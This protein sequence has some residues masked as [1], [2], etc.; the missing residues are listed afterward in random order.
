MSIKL[1]VS[2]RNLVINVG[3]LKTHSEAF[4]QA[5]SKRPWFVLELDSL[6][7]DG[8]FIAVGRMR[9]DLDS[10]IKACVV[11]PLGPLIQQLRQRL[12]AEEIQ[13]LQPEITFPPLGIAKGASR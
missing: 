10:S 9:A 1:V 12:A 4:F 2:L 11:V 13:T 5:G 8:E 6:V 7:F 3:M